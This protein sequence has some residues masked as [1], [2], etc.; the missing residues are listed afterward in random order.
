MTSVIFLIAASI[1]P[2]VD[3]GVVRNFSLFK[4]ITCTGLESSLSQCTP[5]TSE[6][7]PWCPHTNIAI[8]CFSK[9][10]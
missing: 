8:R 4:N 3:Y 1:I 6:C 7:T 9:L 5:H 2:T 10:D